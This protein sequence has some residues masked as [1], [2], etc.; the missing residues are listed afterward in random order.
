MLNIDTVN[1]SLLYESINNQYNYYFS[2]G[3]PNDIKKI[4]ENIKPTKCN[5]L[6]CQDESFYYAKKLIPIIGADRIALCGGMY[7][8]DEDSEPIGHYWLEIDGFVF[9]PTKDQFDESEDFRYESDETY[10]G[11]DLIDYLNNN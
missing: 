11:D 4:I 10:E 6:G 9:D 1:I 8:T 3:F 5:T 7:Y 2:D